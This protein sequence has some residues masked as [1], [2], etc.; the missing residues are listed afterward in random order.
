MTIID[1]ISEKILIKSMK[2]FAFFI[3]YLF[4]TL[5][6]ISFS[7][8]SVKIN[9]VE[10]NPSG[11][12]TNL[13]WIELYNDGGSVNLS[14]WLIQ[15]EALVNYSLPSVI[16]TDFYVLDGQDFTLDA[17]KNFTLYQGSIKRDNPDLLF[18][19]LSD[20][21]NTWSRIPDGNNSFVFQA[22]TKGLP[23]IPNL[24]ESQSESPLCILSTNNVT[25][26][27]E[28]SGFCIENVTFSV[29]INNIWTNYTGINTIGDNYSIFLHS[30]NFT[31]AETI[32][33]NVSAQDCFD[34]TLQNGKSFY[35][36]PRT[37]LSV[38]P[39]APDGLN[40][41]YVTE[42]V[43]TLTNLNI[44]PAQLFYQWDS[45]G[46]FN[47]IS[48]FGLENAENDINN[49]TGGILDLHYWSDSCNESESVNFSKID[50]QDPEI[51][52]LNLKPSNN[53]I[54]HTTFS[55]LIQAYID[56]RFGSNSGINKTSVKMFIDGIL[57]PA[58]VYDVSD[59]DAIINFT[60]NLSSGNHNI[61]VFAEDFSGRN[62]SSSWFFTINFTGIFNLNVHSPNN[63]SYDTTRIPFNITTSE[64]V[65]LIEYVN[66]NDI[67]PRFNTLCRNCK[68]YGFVRKVTKALREGNN[69][70]TIRAVDYERNVKEQNIS[71]FI[72]SKAP[73]I[74][75]TLPKNNAVVN[76]SFF[77]V[78]YT[79]DNLQNVSLIF[80][81]TIILANCTSGT[82]K[83]CSTSA[84]LA[85]FNNQTITYRF[86]VSDALRT[87]KSKN[88][89]VFVDTISP[90]LNINSPNN[91]NYTTTKIPFNITI[92][93]PVLL[94]FSKD[95]KWRTLCNNCRDYG[96]RTPKTQLF[97][98]GIQNITIRARDKAGNSD[99]EMISF[100]VN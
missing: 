18:D 19:D 48:P 57:K 32:N 52:A 87:T 90:I 73:K 49:Q 91:I 75:T 42:P 72:D 64:K 59:I 54:V 93:E 69:T 22:S 81:S 34:R 96:L 85:S 29:Q 14:G 56:E 92:S 21:D 43:F 79:E 100:N 83:N 15:D 45:Q 16:I 99:V 11:S 35:V 26:T 89:T 8:A 50:L 25:L 97:K 30:G 74:I 65:S 5:S 6:L 9:E 61:T 68:E 60:E 7:S 71:L 55:P 62:A 31:G 3:L 12:D 63:L 78:K 80:N 95:G 67:K 27:A 76:G 82:N 66:H 58:N 88:I 20:N 10:I 13:E 17:N 36:S 46:V 51:N 40:G 77:F 28:V 53:S 84:N 37:S 70:L 98:P 86:E 47:Y 41:W 94:E 39:S 38:F 23:N 33:W 24:I 2:N 1:Y 4:L 44:T